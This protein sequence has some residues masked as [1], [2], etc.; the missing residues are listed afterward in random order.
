M[1]SSPIPKDL[2][3]SRS[4]AIN[5]NTA[6]EL[7]RDRPF[8][9]IEEEI[10]SGPQALS[11]DIEI[12]NGESDEYA[13]FGLGSRCEN[14]TSLENTIDWEPYRLWCADHFD[15]SRPKSSMYGVSPIV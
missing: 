2:L 9:G 3:D 6:N 5:L 1:A 14:R 7:F 4:F 8:G 10:G 15:G 13:V 12:G 11:F